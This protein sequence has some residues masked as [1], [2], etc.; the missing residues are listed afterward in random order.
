M[1]LEILPRG[2]GAQWQ[3]A[4]VQ[5]LIDSWKGI[6]FI[7]EQFALGFSPQPGGS[8]LP[9][10]VLRFP[11]IP[12]F[13]GVNI[14]LEAEGCVHTGDSALRMATLNRRGWLAGSARKRDSRIASA[15]GK[16]PALLRNPSSV[17]DSRQYNYR[18]WP[19][20]LA[21][22]CLAGQQLRA[23]RIGRAVEIA[24]RVEDET[25]KGF[26]PRRC[27]DHLRSANR[28]YSRS[29]LDFPII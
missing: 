9:I 2:P 11:A 17:R 3:G 27:L 7:S 1:D 21:P 8:A 10:P 13:V 16:N 22:S 24:G 20:P 15:F 14:R 26:R 19:S 29:R 23:A 12:N 25:S 28:L 4:L 18:C 5:F 6:H